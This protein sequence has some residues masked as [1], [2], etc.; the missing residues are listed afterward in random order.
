MVGRN[1]RDVVIKSHRLNITLDSDSYESLK[2][3]ANQK[4]AP[5]SLVANDLI[6]RALEANQDR[7]W[8]QEAL[9]REKSLISVK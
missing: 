1:S 9:K 4:G 5:L 2:M 6:R 7:F 8:Y 3:M